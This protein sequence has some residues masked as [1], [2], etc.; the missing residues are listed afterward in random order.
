MLIGAL[1]PAPAA[2]AP[3]PTVRIIGGEPVADGDHPYLA[4]LLVRAIPSRPVAFTCGGSV[5][6]P[7]W[8]IT[9]AHCVID[10]HNDYGGRHPG[11]RGF[12]FVAPEHLDVL[13]GTAS[14]LDG[15]GG[16]RIPVA[17]IY[18][19]PSYSGPDNDYDVALLQLARPT[20]AP[21]VPVIGTTGVELGL[22]SAGRIA[23]AAGWGY[24]GADLYP[25]RAHHVDL[26]IQTDQS[27][28]AIYP[29]GRTVDGSPTEYRSESMLCAGNLVGGSDSCHGDS[30]GPLVTESN[31]QHRL[32]GLVSWGDGCA[33]PGLPGV[34]ARMK[35]VSTWVHHQTRFGPFAPDGLAF[36]QRQFLDLV[37]REP[38]GAEA[39]RWYQRLRTEPP[40]ALVEHLMRSTRF[41][42]PVESTI[43]LYR[44]M[45]LRQPDT[46]GLA[47]WV[48][49]RRTGRTL[50]A[51]A[52]FF[53][54]SAEVQARYGGL[55]NPDLVDLI[56][57]NVLGRA[58][59]DAGRA[60]WIAQLT[61]SPSRAPVSR[62]RLLAQFSDSPEH[63]HRTATPVRVIASWFGLNRRVPTPPEMGAGAALSRSALIENLLAGLPYAGRF[64]R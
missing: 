49:T 17:G 22:D 39:I 7:T 63:R 53:V 58:P 19:H 46:G 4:A 36:I 23:T 38:T 24:L 27:C 21:A 51:T 52:D 5:I 55:T 3:P 16:Q 50:E 56:Y 14:I 10:R 33:R 34:Y 41:A 37:D 40:A 26:P 12:D 44:A 11:P 28:A 32:I 61:G 25:D 6:A 2:A 42:D 47:Y 59:D 45:F 60:Y 54:T 13:T 8:V 35:A 62:G 15:G 43:R 30:G 57:R 20:T 18:P 29:E 48:A 31:G 1:A 64:A 9:A